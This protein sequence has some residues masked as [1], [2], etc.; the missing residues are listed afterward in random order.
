MKIV[1]KLKKGLS[2]VI[3]EHA[4]SIALAAILTIIAMVFCGLSEKD[5]E[6]LLTVLKYVY[7][8]LFAA[9]ISALLCESIHLY[10]KAN[11]IKK[12]IL[13]VVI[14]I[15][16]VVTS[17]LNVAS[18]GVDFSYITYGDAYDFTAQGFF[19]GLYTSLMILYLCLIIFFCYKKSKESFEIYVA[20]AFCGVM[21]AELLCVILLIGSIL[22][23]EIIDSLLIH[24]MW[25]YYVMDRVILFIF[26]FVAYPCAIVGIS[27]TD[28]EISKFGKAILGYVFV[29]LL[30]IAY[31][32]IY[33]YMFKIIITWTFPSNEVFGILMTLF[34]FGIGVWTMGYSCGDNIFRKIAG[35][36]PF[37]FIPFIVLQIMCLQIRISEYGFTTDRYLGMMLIIFEL[38]YMVLYAIRFFGKK[39][40]VANSLFIVS[41]LAI[42][43][44]IVPFVNVSSV[45]LV[46]QKS[47]IEK[48]LSLGDDASATV[49][50]EA[51][52]AYRVIWREGGESG[53]MYLDKSLS[54]DQK[55]FLDYS[56]YYYYSHHNNFYIDVNGY[57]VDEIDTSDVETVYIISNNIKDDEGIDTSSVNI[58]GQNPDEVLAT[59]DIKDMV[60]TLIEKDS[61][62]ASD[63]ELSVSIE[64]EYITEEGYKFIITSIMV[65]GEKED[66]TTV[67]NINICGYL[68]K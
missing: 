37:L 6:L 4:V 53:K 39:D 41:I 19:G 11:N 43:T 22:I 9:S 58:Y 54:Q 26:G 18:D 45:V 28:H 8:I 13:F 1:E 65:K 66:E 25:N 56:S 24:I 30:S 32:I 40:I 29:S 31:V 55:Y 60:D 21:K 33:I 47:K 61:E 64:Q 3:T 38:V 10:H 17:I 62:G 34:V 51:R 50:E 49:I 57:K 68:L 15:T 48:Y 23:I 7:A 63:Y 5:H 67:T 52:D 46:S 42:V 12:I 14:M 16:G 35:I 36:L 44:L 27:D 59:L 20:K 2:K